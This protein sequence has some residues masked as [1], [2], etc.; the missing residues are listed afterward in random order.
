MSYN[1]YFIHWTENGKLT[2][3]K[4]NSDI[5]TNCSVFLT[6]LKAFKCDSGDIN[7]LNHSYAWILYL[8][9]KLVSK[10]IIAQ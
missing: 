1:H 10:Y 2:I 9:G 6:P 5:N 8:T 3:W 4:N 7:D